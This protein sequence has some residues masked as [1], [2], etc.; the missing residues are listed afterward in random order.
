MN[1]VF[2]NIKYKN[3]LSREDYIFRLVKEKK[4][5]FINGIKQLDNLG[6]I[7]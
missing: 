4:N 7:L 1:R 5:Y 6:R 2:I 3:L